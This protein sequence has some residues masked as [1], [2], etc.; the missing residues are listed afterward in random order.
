[1]KQRFITAALCLLIALIPSIAGAEALSPRPERDILLLT[2]FSD[3]D[4]GAY[5]AMFVDTLGD[6]YQIDMTANGYDT[7]GE[8]CPIMLSLP[9]DFRTGTLSAEELAHITA[10]IANIDSDMGAAYSVDRQSIGKYSMFAF[11]PGASGNDAL[12]IMTSG[13]SLSEN[14]SAAAQELQAWL[15]GY[16]PP[17]RFLDKSR[18][19]YGDSAPMS[20]TLNTEAGSWTLAR[21]GDTATLSREGAEP[22]T[23]DSAAFSS[24]LSLLDAAGARDWPAPGEGSAALTVEYVDG[25][26]ASDAQSHPELISSLEQMFS[27][28]KIN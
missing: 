23:L 2:T 7:C 9:S 5:E 19:A 24:I 10:L 13:A 27:I 8:I 6:V 12:T 3:I 18:I 14:M 4:S 25:Q 17:E 20:L 22:A 16:L 11:R 15:R 28:G 1:M 21:T 26:H